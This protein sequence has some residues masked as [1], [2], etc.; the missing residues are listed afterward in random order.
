MCTCTSVSSLGQKHTKMLHML[1]LGE[2]H[3]V[4]LHQAGGGEGAEG[5]WGDLHVLGFVVLEDAC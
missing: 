5:G 2:P 4:L 1:Q 3:Q